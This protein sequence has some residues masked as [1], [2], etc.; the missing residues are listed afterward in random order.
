M[1]E[2]SL[3]VKLEADGSALVNAAAQGASALN[4]LGE[5]SGRL[6]TAL[7]GATKASVQMNASMLQ[8]AK[9]SFAFSAVNSALGQLTSL[10]GSLPRSGIA[11]VSSMQ[12]AQLGIAGV[13]SSMTEV[14]GKA[15]T[16]GEAM[17][18]SGEV[19]KAL[20]ADAL[21]TAATTQELVGAFQSMVGP[22]LAAGGTLEQIQKLATTGVVA[23]KA[24][25]LESRQVIQELRDLVQGGITPASS[26]LATS[27]GL[28]DADIQKAK[29]SAEGLFVFLERRLAG[30]AQA[31]EGYGNT[32]AGSVAQLKESA[33][34]SA[35]AVSA[36]LVGALTTQAQKLGAALNNPETTRGLSA[37][38]EKAA[39]VATA[40]GEAAQFA[41]RYSGALLTLSSA[42]SA[43][44]IGTFV[45]GLVQATAAKLEAMSASRLAAAQAAAESAGNTQVALSSRAKLQAYLAELAAAVSAAQARQQY[46]AIL[47]AEAEA[48]AAAATGIAR[49]A[50]VETAVVPLQ[51]ELAAA[52]AATAGA[53]GALTA[54]TNASSVA[55]RGMG[56]VVGAL[57]GP[58]GIAITALIALVMWMKSAKDEADR[59]AK[60]DLS[61]GRIKRTVAAGGQV[62]QRDVGIVQAHV[63]DLKEKRDE[64]M[65]ARGEIS[66]LA[67]QPAP[68]GG[69]DGNLFD[70]AAGQAN[71]G[72]LTNAPSRRLAGLNADIAEYEDLLVRAQAAAATGGAVGANAAGQIGLK[73]GVS[74]K[75]LDELF[76]SVKTAASINKE[77][78]EKLAALEKAWADERARMVKRGAPQTEIDADQAR[79]V[80]TRKKIQDDLKKALL[81][82]QKDA[83]EAAVARRKAALDDATTQAALA[84]DLRERELVE[85]QRGLDRETVTLETFYAEKRTRTE[86]DIKDQIGLKRQ[87][88]AGIAALPAGNAAE[89]AQRRGQQAKLLGEIEQLQIKHGF[90]SIEIAREQEQKKLELAE[91]A[92]RRRV[93]VLQRGADAELDLVR[94][95]RAVGE[96]S[97][98]QLAAAE[99]EAAERRVQIEIDAAERILAARRLADAPAE[100]VKAGEDDVAGARARQRADRAARLAGVGER[101]RRLREQT[102]DIRLQIDADPARREI[103]DAE[104]DI[105]RLREQAESDEVVLRFQLSAEKDPRE[106]ERI[107]GLLT[108]LGAETTDAIVA[109]NEQLADR[110]KPGW[111]KM[112]EGW[113]DSQRLM[114]DAAD[115][116][117]DTLL[118]GGEDA[119]VQLA[120]T[121]KLNVKSLLRDLQALAGR[122][123]WRQLIGGEQGQQGVG[124]LADLL[125]ARGRGLTVPNYSGREGDR[126]FMGPLPEAGA[127]TAT[128][129]ATAGAV[130]PMNDLAQAATAAAVA[131]R[132]LAPGGG[133][134]AGGVQIGDWQSIK[135]FGGSDGTQGAG[136]KASESAAA[137]AENMNMAADAAG[138]MANAA[139]RSADASTMQSAAVAANALG[140]GRL[141]Q[142]LQLTTVTMTLFEA[143]TKAAAAM[144]AAG[145]AMS[146]FGG[147]EAA[148]AMFT[149]SSRFAAGAAFTNSVVT[150]STMF[151]YRSG[152]RW[153][154]GEMGEAGPEA[155]VPLKSRGGAFEMDAVDERGRPVRGGVRL[156]RGRSGRLS[157]V[158]GEASRHASGGFFS[159]ALL[160]APRV[161]FA[162]GGFV[163]G[164]ASMQ[165][166]AARTEPSASAR[167]GMSLVQHINVAPGVD[168]NAVMLAM[169]QAKAAAV[170]EIEQR[171]QRNRSAY[172]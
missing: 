98:G 128:T 14:D 105:A 85:L 61:V 150:A 166:V 99:A 161:Q 13:L 143:A 70:E 45:A 36:P 155:I 171:M 89:M 24:L 104:R 96:A 66:D 144:K 122:T 34:R 31:A 53:Q 123:L 80:Q 159:A 91:Q 71:G 163:S 62:D 129:A 49:L 86:A 30:F 15:I 63:N 56:L 72:S 137:V 48:S 134:G 145:S 7:D 156:A 79:Y 73:A 125:G 39:F 118:K 55:S 1:A 119:F 133:P 84:H 78:Q 90:V 121:G 76:D 135:N 110:L 20:S 26:T 154:L 57:G 117:M 102:A 27:L 131:L 60:V 170:A 44:K 124:W 132:G 109:R 2:Y 43:V 54:A 148:G 165:D 94:L 23:T 93:A 97:A 172:R 68:Q 139:A 18:R 152:G 157:A 9:A 112:V 147:G 140:F 164:R 81:G 75:A 138:K 37:I 87:E 22:G 167:E 25:G 74:R 115:E 50:L 126:N 113:R 103:A 162:G 106:I 42:Y 35:G 168:R 169:Q 58:I 136:G 47:L 8:V 40:L 19:V 65:I 3:R 142:V 141:G 52:T 10:L 158:V 95:R 46:I 51:R 116:T 82:E 83:S 33:E 6:R 38:G 108:T 130:L 16:F 111:Q 69:V 17:R 28:K 32:L 12:T 149:G 21:R 59:L 41:L 29:S 64:L 146:A 4:R 114:R 153:R 127:S 5:Q 101:V 151:R 88:L 77:A 160:A 107:R 11:F 92:E 67:S 100:Q 120:Q